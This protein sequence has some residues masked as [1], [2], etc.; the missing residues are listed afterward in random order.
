MKKK[1]HIL[2][3]FNLIPPKSEEEIKVLEERDNSI[4]YSF[5]L[6]FFITLIYF[7]MVWVDVYIV[8]PRINKLEKTIAKQNEQIKTYDVV[9]ELKGELF[10]KTQIL[11]PLLELDIET[12]KLLQNSDLIVNDVNN[13]KIITYVREPD[14]TF[15]ITVLVDSYKDVIA[16]LD[17][18]KNI[19][20]IENVFLRQARKF[21]RSENIKV[22]LSFVIKSDLT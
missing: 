17:N 9:R 12:I 21:D 7:L 5:L 8:V 3:K 19:E 22:T 16:I 20:E 18:A 6:I 11:E 13:A 2:F 14:G 1:Q 15:V 4:F 10:V